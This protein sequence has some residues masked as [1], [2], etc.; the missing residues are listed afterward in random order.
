MRKRSLGLLVALLCLYRP[1]LP[2]EDPA[3][4]GTHAEISTEKLFVHRHALR[5][6]PGLTS[7]AQA[8]LV[9]RAKDVGEI[10]VLEDS[11]DIVVGSIA[12]NLDQTS[13]AFIPVTEGG[14]RYRFETGAGSYDTAAAAGGTVLAGLGDDDSRK[15]A[16]PFPFPFY[17]QSYRELYVNS[18]GNLTFGAPD[19][20]TSSRSLGRMV[21]GAPRIAPLFRDLDPPR[22]T[23]GV[24]VL[25]EPGRLVVSW[26]GVPEYS[27]FGS[28]RICT[29]Q[30]RL[31]PGGRIEF[32]YGGVG[33]TEAVVGISP[34]GRL[35]TTSAVSFRDGA[36]EEY[37]GTVAQRFADRQEVDI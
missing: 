22:A 1:A 37:A 10:A 27:S 35:G 29:F 6:R 4:C 13:L 3:S 33:S 11:G 14:V 12:F 18:D 9:A 7:R 34:G 31:L 8:D 36:S 32:A 16:L 5:T 19:D 30:V 20:A 21:V 23:V 26:A 28:G 2:V 17:G 25:S 24:T 15:V